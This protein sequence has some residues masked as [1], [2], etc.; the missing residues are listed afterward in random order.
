MFNGFVTVSHFR[1]SFYPQLLSM[2][3]G[4]IYLPINFVSFCAL[5]KN[6]FFVEP[7]VSPYS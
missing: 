6:L 7:F 1:L 5:E 2:N 4:P 3:L